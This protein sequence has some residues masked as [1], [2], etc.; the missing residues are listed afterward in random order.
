MHAVK[1]KLILLTP[2]FLLLTHYLAVFPHEYAHSF[3]AWVLGYKSNPLAINYGGTSWP[4]LL[5]LTHIDEQVDYAMIFSAGHNHEAALIAFAGAGIANGLLFILSFWLLSRE[6]VQQQP[7]LFYFMFLFN[8]MNLGNFYDYVPIRTFVTHGDVAHVVMGLGISPWGVYA[9]GGYL[10][11]CLIWH[12]F[13]RTMILAFISLNF[14]STSLKASLMVL[15]VAVLFG[16]FAIPGF[17][18]YGD[19]S[20]FLSA[21]SFLAIP[22]LIVA[23]WPTRAWVLRQLSVI[24]QPLHH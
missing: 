11:A 18:G 24:G 7:Y 22:G 2:L 19:I 21:T 12:F 3:M 20:Y 4:N 23:L 10:V 8:L 5:L 6:R 15:C 13:T 1:I 17:F 9:C 16:F 14:V